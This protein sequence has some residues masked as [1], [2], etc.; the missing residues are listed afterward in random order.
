[1]VENLSEKLEIMQWLFERGFEPKYWLELE[2][3]KFEN[4]ELINFKNKNIAGGIDRL[5]MW[6]PLEQVLE[7]L[8]KVRIPCEIFKEQRGR[9]YI[10]LIESDYSN[11][12]IYNFGFAQWCQEY[13]DQHPSLNIELD[14]N[15]DIHLAALKLLKQV[16][17]Q[18]P[19]EVEK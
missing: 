3:I 12:F 18:F 7:L 10:F 4:L 13:Y 16:V 8:M 14:R 1:M 11:A 2:S 19:E 5:G 17:E 9:D 6:Y 15:S